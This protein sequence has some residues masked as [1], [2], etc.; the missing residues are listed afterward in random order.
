MDKIIWKEY[1]NTDFDIIDFQHKILVE[2]INELIEL[3]NTGYNQEQLYNLFTF[4]ESYTHYHFDT[5]E[6]FF[7]HFDYSQL[8]DHIAE[9]NFFREKVKNLKNE[10]KFDN[11]IIDEDLLIFLIDWVLNHIL[12]TDKKFAEELKKSIETNKI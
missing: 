3:Y 1:F 12:G 5:E 6:K 4:L 10:I 8:N 9:H 2:R 11:K 7:R